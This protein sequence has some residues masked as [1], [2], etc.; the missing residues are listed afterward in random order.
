MKHGIAF[1]KLSRT[2]SHRM[3]MLRNMVTSLFE[4]EQIKTTLPKAR[5]AARLAEKMITMGKNGSRES[6]ARASALVLKPEIIPKLFGPLARRYISRP[7]GYT[8]IHKYGNRPG[9]NA[10]V[11]ILELVDNPR[12]LRYEI[13]ARAVGWELLNK[14]L[15]SGKTPL[16]I[17]NQGVGD[18]ES[19][20]NSES[21]IGFGEAEGVL[22]PKTRWNLQKVLRY[23][24][25]S[26]PSE[27]GHKIGRYVDQVLASPLTP[28]RNGGERYT[29]GR[30]LLGDGE[31]SAMQVAQGALGKR[32]LPPILARTLDQQSIPR[33]QS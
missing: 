10:P 27:I 33:K 26:G 20:I 16:S 7:G 24:G 30:V 29:A 11:A 6:R 23:R 18:V 8:R 5:E 17:V 2:T 15:K 21:S 4:H 13:T 12:D 22:R 3:L 28:E 25:L 1:R 14:K 32:R 19:I 9:D 31:V